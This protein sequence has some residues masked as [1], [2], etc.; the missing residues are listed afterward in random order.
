MVALAA[1]RGFDWLGALDSE[2]SESQCLGVRARL[3]KVLCRVARA[4]G[5]V[6][7]VMPLTLLLLLFQIRSSHDLQ[8]FARSLLRSAMR[9]SPR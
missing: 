3:V 8:D 9:S 2:I 5:D 4:V 1:L 7:I 6:V